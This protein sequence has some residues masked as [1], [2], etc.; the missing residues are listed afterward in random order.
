M[1]RQVISTKFTYVVNEIHDDGTIS[2]RMDT[3]KVPNEKDPMRA[4][5]K[6]AKMVG[7]FAPI[8]TEL[9]SNLWTCE[10]A[11][12]FAIAMCGEDKPYTPTENEGKGE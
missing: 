10:D 8:K 1:Q 6:A 9:V 2:S 3:V 4:Y 5:K 12:F 7:N 11:D